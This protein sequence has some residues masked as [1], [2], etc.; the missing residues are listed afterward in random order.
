MSTR[1]CVVDRLLAL[2]AVLLP[3]YYSGSIL[4]PH[5]LLET[6]SP[7]SLPRDINTQTTSPSF[8]SVH[9]SIQQAHEARRLGVYLGMIGGGWWLVTGQAP[10]FT[11]VPGQVLEVVIRTSMGKKR[12]QGLDLIR[13]A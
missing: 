4:R 7:D 5:S 1:P 2:L 12:I 11:R 3:K 6:F 8:G 10:Y 9:A 13:Y